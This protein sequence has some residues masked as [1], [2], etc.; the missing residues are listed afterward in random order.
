MLRT[1][2]QAGSVLLDRGMRFKAGFLHFTIRQ[3][4]L[5]TL[6]YISKIYTELL[7]DDEALKNTTFKGSYAFVPE[8]A[9]RMA[10]ILAYSILNNRLKIMLF[11]GLLAKYLLWNVK[12]DKLFSL[13]STLL[14]LNNVSDFTNSIRLIHALRMMKPKESLVEKPEKD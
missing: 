3:S 8:N 12:P 6:L 5:G 1:E 13:I 7:I 11:S 4:Y 10:K 2:N 14:I 9:K